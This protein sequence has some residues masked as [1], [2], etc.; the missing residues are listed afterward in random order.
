MEQEYSPPKI[1]VPVFVLSLFE[2][3]WEIIIRKCGGKN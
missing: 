3:K 1:N 2:L